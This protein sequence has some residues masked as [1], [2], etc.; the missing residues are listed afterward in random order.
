MHDQ[1]IPEVDADLLVLLSRGGSTRQIAE[2]RGTTI[3]RVRRDTRELRRRLD[4]STNIH[5]V[6]IAIRRGII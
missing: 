4:A 5:A 1:A 2:E 6:V 3:E